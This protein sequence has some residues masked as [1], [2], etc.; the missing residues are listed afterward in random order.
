MAILGTAGL[1][2]LARQ[3]G[4]IDAVRPLLLALR[5]SGYFLSDRLS[6]AVLAQ[7]GE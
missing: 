6:E 1:L 7:S 2:L 4:A 5:Q 3:A